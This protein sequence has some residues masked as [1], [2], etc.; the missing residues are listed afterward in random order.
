MTPS[1]RPGSLRSVSDNCG[2]SRRVRISIARKHT[3]I[4]DRYEPIY[5]W[6]ANRSLLRIA[7]S[8]PMMPPNM[9][10]ASVNEIAFALKDSL[11]ASAAANR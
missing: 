5:I 9:P 8:G 6:S 4:N 1:G 10:P 2:I 3:A 7:I 11:A